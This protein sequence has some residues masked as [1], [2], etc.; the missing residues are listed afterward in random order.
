M[1]RIRIRLA[2][3]S[4]NGMLP[5]IHHEVTI[6]GVDIQ[7]TV[8]NRVARIFAALF[9]GEVDV[10]EM[11]LAELVYYVSRD[12]AEF[13]AIPVF[14]S[15]VFRH[16]HLFC[17]QQAGIGAPENLTG[18]KIG[19]QRW[20]QTAGVWMRGMLAE[21]YGISPSTTQWYVASTHHCQDD[22]EEEVHP[23]D[24]SVIRRYETGSPFGAEDAYRALLTGEVDVMG[25]TEVQAPLLLADARVRRLFEDY[26]AEEVAY[27]KRTRFFPIMHVLAMRRQLAESRPELPAQLFR[28]CSQAKRLAQETMRA[29]PSWGLAWKDRYLEDEQAIFGGDPWPFGVSANHHVLDKF[30]SYCFQ[31]GIAARE[32][33]PRELFHP[34]TWELEDE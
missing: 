10:S 25:V 27:Y 12:K 15:R 22:S 8:D 20:V 33:T 13:A 7:S 32:L 24:G 3:R 17:Y 26:R 19:F 23:R 14:P 18:R 28:A 31:Q 30:I 5:I 29:I 21:E 34:S 2:S 1:E 9:E 11:S 16:G 6:P 4:Y